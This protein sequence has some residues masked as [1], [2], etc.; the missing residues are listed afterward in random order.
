[1]FDI[2]SFKRWKRDNLRSYPRLGSRDTKE[3]EY[4]EEPPA[5]SHTLSTVS[6][7][8]ALTALAGSHS[9]ADGG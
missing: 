9:M 5:S 6:Q 7:W 3:P 2:S 4:L 1:M 8:W